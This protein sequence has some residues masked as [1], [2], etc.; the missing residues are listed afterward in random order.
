[1]FKPRPRVLLVLLLTFKVAACG[2]GES[3][4]APTPQYARGTETLSGPPIAAHSSLCTNFNNARAGAVYA[5]V[6]PPSIRVILAAGTCSAPGQILAEKDGEVSNVE[7]PAG[8]NHIT[9]SNQSDV[10][11]SF[12]LSVTHWF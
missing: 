12:S 6:I 1:M 10:A 4:A 3:P 7:A 9:L 8:S 11:M 2:G 5:A